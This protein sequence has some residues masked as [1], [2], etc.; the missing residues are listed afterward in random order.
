MGVLFCFTSGCGSKSDT[1]LINPDET[2]QY[3]PEEQASQE[4][5]DAARESAKQ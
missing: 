1:T 5:M 4:Q 2:Y 3:T